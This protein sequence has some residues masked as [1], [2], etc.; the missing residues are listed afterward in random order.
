MKVVAQGPWAWTLF[1]DD[2][3]MLVLSTLCGTVAQYGLEMALSPS[4][5]ENYERRGIDAVDALASDVSHDPSAY[6]A[7][8]IDGFVRRPEVQEAFDRWKSAQVR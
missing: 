2:T 8:A 7:R 1:Q 3:G 5:A 6:A 4:E